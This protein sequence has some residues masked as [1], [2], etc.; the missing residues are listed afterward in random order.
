LYS[1]LIGWVLLLA[2]TFAAADATAVSE[3]GGTSIAIFEAAMGSAWVKFILIISTMGQLFCGMSCVTSASRMTFAF[4]RDGAIPGHRLW[5]RLNHHRVPYM[6]VLFIGFWALVITLPALFG[7]ADGFPVAFFAVV[8]IAVIGLYIAYVIPVFLRW[9]QGESYERGPWNLGSKYKWLN[10]IAVLWVA[11]CVVIFSL[12]FTPA[13]VPWASDFNWSSFNYAPAM[14]IAVIILATIL[15][16]TGGSKHF[17]SPAEDM[18]A[19][20][21]ELEVEIGAPPRFPEAP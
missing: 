4:S 5:T 6:S 21:H 8:S 15:W 14:V 10:P 20:A 3:G 13:A 19:E 9:R 17:H 12:P 7:N 2:I 18:G 16:F 1:G 11:L